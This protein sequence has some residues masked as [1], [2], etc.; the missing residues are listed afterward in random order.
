MLPLKARGRIKFLLMEE[1]IYQNTLVQRG[2]K[3][4]I[5][6]VNRSGGHYVTLTSGDEKVRDLLIPEEGSVD[7]ENYSAAAVFKEVIEAEERWITDNR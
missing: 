2:K 1:T 4:I 6:I 3:Y 7:I 5:Q